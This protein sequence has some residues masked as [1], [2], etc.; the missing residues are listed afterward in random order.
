MLMSATRAAG[1]E[2]RPDVLMIAVDDLNTWTGFLGGH[3]QA[4]SPNMDALARR[5]VTFRQAYAPVPYC[6][7]T[8][9][10]TMWGQDPDRSGVFVK[11]GLGGLRGQPA[12]DRLFKQAGYATHGAGKIFHGAPPDASA[13][14]SY[15][16]S[17]KPSRQWRENSTT[18]ICAYT[19]LTP[20][21]DPAVDW[22]LVSSL[23]DMRDYWTASYLDEIHD[24]TDPDQPLFAA[25]GFHDPH[26]PFFLPQDYWAPFADMDMETPDI[27]RVLPAG[28]PRE[29]RAWIENPSNMPFLARALCD[30][31]LS[32]FGHS[33]IDLIRRSGILEELVRGYL[34]SV[35]FVDD[36]IG[37][38]LR[39]LEASGR[40]ENTI[41]VLWSDHGYH[42]GEKLHW[43]KFTLWE[44][45][46][47]VPMLLHLPP[48][49]DP[50]GR[51][52]G[53]AHDTP[54]STVDILATLAELCGID[55]P[56]GRDSLSLMRLLEGQAER[57][58]ALTTW[59]AGSHSIRQDRWRYTRYS[60]G[61]QELYDLVE[62]PACERNLAGR[63]DSR[64]ELRRLEAALAD[65]L[66][67]GA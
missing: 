61:G 38:A 14:D 27:D 2:N 6:Y 58:P 67:Q 54:V 35:Y 33:Y 32:T 47:R 25:L 15:L 42:L 62:D 7:P 53:A 3:S 41:V 11:E 22:G 44:E 40:A 28:I 51:F 39:S 24:R 12:M 18:P 57:R 23:T 21:P 52:A 63:P 29:A 56:A 5:A 36:M 49:L 66:G 9:V 16:R 20:R 4:L 55:L 60:R 45:A 19:G 31:P 46:T 10:A 17:R 26:T 30:A 50:Q 37:R 43:S 1:R 59:G 64:A 48:S 13:W 34:A 65:R 8:R